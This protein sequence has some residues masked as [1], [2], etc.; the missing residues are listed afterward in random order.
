MFDVKITTAV[1]DARSAVSKLWHRLLGS[2]FKFFFSLDVGSV[3]QQLYL[4]IQIVYWSQKPDIVSNKIMFLCYAQ[5]IFV[6][7]FFL[8]FGRS[9]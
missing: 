3:Y 8:F 5:H 9:K 4:T 6:P 7:N 1:H 2:L